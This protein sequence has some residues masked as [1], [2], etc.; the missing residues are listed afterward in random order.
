MWKR[1]LIQVFFFFL[2]SNCVQLFYVV[3]HCFHTQ[4]SLGKPAA[5]GLDFLFHAMNSQ[6]D[7][8][9]Q[10]RIYTQDI[11]SST[12]RSVLHYIYTRGKIMTETISI[13]NRQTKFI[14]KTFE[15]LLGWHR[16]DI[17]W[18]FIAGNFVLWE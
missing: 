1:T 18:Q 8:K 7:I 6:C 11:I 10:W 15:Q 4:L 16:I 14:H 2:L 3:F 17:I 12:T 9:I 13:H 5:S